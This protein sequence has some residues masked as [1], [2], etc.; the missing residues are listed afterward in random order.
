LAVV[1]PI[2]HSITRYVLSQE[3]A[4]IAAGED[5]GAVYVLSSRADVILRIDPSDGSELGRVLIS[6]RT[7]RS[8]IRPNDVQGLRPRLV[9]NASNETVY[10]TVPEA[11][12]LAAVT[13]GSFPII[14]REIPQPNIPDAAMAAD[15]PE[16]LWPASVWGDP[17]NALGH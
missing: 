17:T 15:F 11:G 7:G 14:A 12:S 3:P 2:S 8:A 9:L 1:E 10:A 6:G 4:A 5:S 16:A 13:E